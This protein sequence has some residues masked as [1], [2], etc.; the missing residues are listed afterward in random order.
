MPS[1]PPQPRGRKRLVVG[2]T[3]RIGAGK[4]SAAR[5]LQQTH[6]FQY[7]R[8]SHVLSEWMDTDPGAKSRLQEVGWE[9][10]SGGMQAE[11]NTRLIARV[12]PGQDCAVDGLRH[13]LDYDSLREA[14]SSTFHL[15]FLDASPE[16]RWRHVQGTGRHKSYEGFLEAD[17]H[18]VEQ[19]IDLLREKASFVI[20][21]EGS[22][23]ELHSHI[24]TVLQ[25]VSAG[26]RK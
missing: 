15:V 13:P 10:M 19:N 9:V 6:G 16:T 17:S 24:E 26:G 22:L 1:Q 2:F 23:A 7:L 4:T 25:Q 5:Y 3:G 12:Q 18:P 14:F 21:N 8:Y 11:L 20:S